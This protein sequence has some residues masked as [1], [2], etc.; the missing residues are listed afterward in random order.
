MIVFPQKIHTQALAL[1]KA[2]S[3][4][5]PILHPAETSTVLSEDVLPTHLYSSMTD[6]EGIPF[7]PRKTR[8][9]YHVPT[10]MLHGSI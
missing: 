4:Q 8:Q 6:W 2:M 1:Q 3:K 9:V 10:C 7:V 5:R